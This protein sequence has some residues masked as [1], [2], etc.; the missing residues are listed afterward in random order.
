MNAGAAWTHFRS[1]AL[2]AGLALSLAGCETFD[3]TNLIPDSKKKLPGE[4]REV[5]PGGV[6]GVP[7]GVPPELVK[8]YQAPPETAEAPPEPEPKQAAKPKPKP[9]PQ[10]KPAPSVAPEYQQS[11]QPPAQTQQGQWPSKP[12]QP[13]QQSAWPASPATGT[14]SR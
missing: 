6:P 5:F 8:G 9:R 2:A 14:F 4:R 13:A 12:S 11:G 7:Q 3:L 1:V 10:P